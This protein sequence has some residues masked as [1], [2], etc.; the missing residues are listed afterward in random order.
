[1]IWW[2]TDDPQLSSHARELIA[3]GENQVF[4]SSIS[5]W[6][7]GTKHAKGHLKIPPSLLRRSLLAE[8]FLSLPFS[9]THAL[10]VASL[11]PIH[12]DPFDRALVAQALA[13]P[14]HILTQDGLL[15]QYGVSVMVV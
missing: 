2:A 1:L 4:F 12:N 3:T 5:L 11:P 7:V 10:Y 13:E 9:D 14:M 8:G 6:E 15:G